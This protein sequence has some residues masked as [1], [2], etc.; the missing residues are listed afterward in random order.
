MFPFVMHLIWIEFVLSSP[1]AAQCYA[2]ER[3]DIV[4]AI[5]LRK[6]IRWTRA[7]KFRIHWICA[8][9]TRWT[10][11]KIAHRY[12]Y[13]IHAHTEFGSKKNW[14]RNDRTKNI[15]YRTSNKPKNKNEKWWWPK[16]HG[17]EMNGNDGRA[18]VS[19]TLSL[20]HLAYACDSDNVCILH[21]I[22]FI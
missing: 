8:P 15:Y 18:A 22:T 20:I 12:S 16:C 19:R 5:C 10:K 17:A 2:C 14:K 9:A 13:F 1:F 3:T 21:I 7:H 11:R 4:C 6:Y